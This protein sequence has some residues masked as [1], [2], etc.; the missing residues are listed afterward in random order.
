M[1]NYFS[2][3]RIALLAVS[4]NIYL[5]NIGKFMKAFEFLIW[6][7]AAMRKVC[8]APALQEF[9]TNATT[10]MIGEK[11]S[12]MILE[13]RAPRAFSVSMESKRASRFLI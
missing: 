13:D 3:L 10:I 11:A 8:A 5:T 12:D 1:A 4:R 7:A 6:Q 2:W 9:N